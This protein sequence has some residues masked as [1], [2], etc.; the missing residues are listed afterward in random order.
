MLLRWYGEREY[1]AAKAGDARTGGPF[2]KST[3]PEYRCNFAKEKEYRE[4][5]AGNTGAGGP[6]RKSA[7]PDIDAAMLQVGLYTS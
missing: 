2:Q 3:E 6:F 4:A 1:P 5:E 7:E